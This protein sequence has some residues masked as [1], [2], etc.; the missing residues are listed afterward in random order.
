[1]VDVETNTIGVAE[2]K[3]EKVYKTPS[4]TLRAVKNY[5]EKNKEKIREYARDRYREKY[6]TDPVFREK[7]QIRKKES[8]LRRKLKKEAEK[9]SQQ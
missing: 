8:N 6:L 5:Q 2:Q 7:E 1:M 9:L 3:E 4:Y